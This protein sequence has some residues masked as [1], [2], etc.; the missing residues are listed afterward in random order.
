VERQAAENFG[1]VTRQ[2][3]EVEARLGVQAALNAKDGIIEAGRNF[4]SLSVQA[5]LNAK[6]GVIEA[7]KNAAAVSLQ[8]ATTTAAT[9][10]LINQRFAE[11]DAQIAECCCEGK[12]LAR[13]LAA[14]L[15]DRMDQ[16]QATNLATQLTDSKLEVA[17]LRARLTTVT[18]T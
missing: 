8:I 15:K 16:I 12:E 11:T 10:A 18:A 14:E 13:A 9:N 6:D 1:S 17:A 7:T 5:T 2:S 4:S 3:A